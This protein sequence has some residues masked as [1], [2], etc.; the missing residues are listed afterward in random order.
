MTTGSTGSGASFS[1]K[2]IIGAEEFIRSDD[3]VIV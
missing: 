3:R 2:K 1:K